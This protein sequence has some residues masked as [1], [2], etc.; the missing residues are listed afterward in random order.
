MFSKFKRRFD[1]C[2]SLP[3]FDLIKN[4]YNDKILEEYYLDK[5]RTVKFFFSF[6][7]H[8]KLL[9]IL[10]YFIFPKKIINLN[11]TD[12]V[13]FGPYSH[14]Y[15]HSLHEFLTRLIFLKKNKKFNVY[16]PKALKKILSSKT[17]KLIF[18]KKNFSFKFFDTDTDIEFRNCNYLTHPNNRW[19]IKGKKK[20]ISNQYKYLMNE[21]RKE[22]TMN[23]IFDKNKSRAKYI[24]V[25]RSNATRRRLLNED[26]LFHQLKKY[27][28]KKFSLK[29]YLTKKQVELSMNCKIMIGYHGAGLTNLIFMKKKSHLIEI[30]NKHYEHEHFKLFSMCQ[31][32]KYKNFQCKENKKNLDGVCDIQEIKNYIINIKKKD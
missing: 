21:L 23:K 18:S 20:K 4:F 30:Y 14:S 25:S 31:K 12:I 26:E 1:V 24:L 29:S 28:F 17:Y 8:F 15:S 7:I 32:I 5:L 10:N 6:K 9:A 16:L 3:T 27:G 13:L 22:V 2:L 19:V 11:N